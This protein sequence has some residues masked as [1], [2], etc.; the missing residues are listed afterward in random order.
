VPSI[1]RVGNDFV[2]FF[3]I[4]FFWHFN[5]LSLFGYIGLFCIKI[6][7]TLGVVGFGLDN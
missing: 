5:N 7:N 1:G 2:Y 3:L 4:A 6:I